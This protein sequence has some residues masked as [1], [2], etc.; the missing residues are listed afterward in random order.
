MDCYWFYEVAT[1]NKSRTANNDIPIKMKEIIQF[2]EDLLE[3][4]K[5]VVAQYEAWLA[6]AKLEEQKIRSLLEITKDCHD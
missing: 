2:L 4:K 1:E 5:K 6:K 3:E